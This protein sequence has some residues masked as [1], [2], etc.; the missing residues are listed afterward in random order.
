MRAMVLDRPSPI[1]TGPLR[2]GEV[3]VPE[4]AD[5]EVRIEVRACGVCRTDLHVCEGD[6]ELRRSPVVPGHQVV[7]IVDAI[8][9]NVID[10]TIGQ[11]VGVAWLHRTCGSCAFCHSGRE[12]LCDAPDFTGWTVDGGFA[13]YVVAPASFTYPLPEGFSD[14]QAAPLLCAGIIGYRCLRMTGIEDWSGAR[15]GLYGFGAAGHVAI[16]IARARGADV[17]VCTRDRDKHRALAEE[18]GATWTGGTMEKPPVFL[19]AGIIFAP[20]G[21]VIPPALSH[22][23]KGGTLVLGGI[24]MSPIPSFLYELLYGERV[25]RSVANN[26]REDGLAF[27]EEAAAVPVRSHTEVFPLEEANEALR[28]LAH[29]GIRGAAVLTV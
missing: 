27:L 2:L 11:R 28:R 24:Q 23:S 20:A 15:L 12:N 7:G 19:D 25:V 8:G 3:P 10:R 29:D 9:A 4:P 6:L 17:Y 21:E 26:T 14:L 13:E 18:L 5:D 1:D 16:Q 22:L